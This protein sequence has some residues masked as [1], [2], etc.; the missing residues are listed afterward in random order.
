MP[1]NN[2]PTAINSAAIIGCNWGLVHLNALQ[3]SQVELKALLDLDINKAQHLAKQHGIANACNDINQ[4][5]PV[6]LV[7][8]ASPAASHLALIEHFKHTAIICEKPLMGLNAAEPLSSWP[9]NLWVNYAFNYLESAQ[10][11]NNLLEPDQPVQA[12]LS[13]Q[14]NLPL[15]FTLEQ[16]FLE[17]ASHPLSWLLHKLGEPKQLSAEKR[18]GQQDN[19][20]LS[21]K[22]AC[23]QHQIDVD[24]SLGG[25][26]GI[27]HQ[28]SLTQGNNS[29]V[30]QGEYVPGHA[31]RF[32]PVLLNG[33]A[34]NQGEYHPQDC[35]LQA[36]H[37][38]TSAIIEHLRGH[39]SKQALLAAGGFS[40]HK[41]L[42]LEQSLLGE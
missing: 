37:R 34:Q 38:S 28:I 25:S 24:F 3:Q 40:P 12:R 27:F 15:N 21:L 11:I 2:T 30:L 39:I 31:W 29:M 7:I 13:S 23:K 41:A 5:P 14:V 8:I 22:L 1:S 26:P 9:Q 10:L 4:L 33:V 20:H 19:Q 17:T 6:D 36:N 42:W 32:A 16:W 18:Q 35:W